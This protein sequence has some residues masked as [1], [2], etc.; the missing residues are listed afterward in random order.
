MLVDTSVW[1][2]HLREGNP[3]LAAALEEREVWCHP[4]VQGELAC[5]N[6]RNR[7]EILSLLSALPQPPLT[8]HAEALALVE[9]RSLMG[10]GLGWVD[11][12]LLGS[13]LLVGIPLWTL[14][15]QLADAAIRLGVGSAPQG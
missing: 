3:T 4:F 10:S 15:R 14:D 5:G 13:A 1:V 2:D 9:E 11:I 7:D 8:T 12:H 6:L